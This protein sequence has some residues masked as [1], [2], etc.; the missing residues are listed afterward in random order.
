MLAPLG[1]IA[2]DPRDSSKGKGTFSVKIG[3]WFH[4]R[5]C[6]MK[7]VNFTFSE[8]TLKSGRPLYATGTIEFEPHQTLTFKE[9]ES[10]IRN[11]KD[12]KK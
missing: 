9:F 4:A 11:V 7:T 6:V 8:Q 12:K 10:F 1:Y 2:G 5:N 3:E